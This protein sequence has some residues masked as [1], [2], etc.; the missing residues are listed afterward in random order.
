M[1]RARCSLLLALTG[2]LLV[3][4][5]VQ[6]SC[7]TARQSLLNLLVRVGITRT[8]IVKRIR[9]LENYY[10]PAWKLVQGLR[11]IRMYQASGPSSIAIPG[12]IISDASEA[13]ES[14]VPLFRPGGFKPGSIKPSHLIRNGLLLIF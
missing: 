13:S 10:V 5:G 14:I 8:D 12:D 4:N 9:V 1:E 11:R 3:T 2:I 7:A 6:V